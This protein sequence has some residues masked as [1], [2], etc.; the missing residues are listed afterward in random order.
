MAGE[1]NWTAFGKS[2]HRTWSDA[3]RESGNLDEVGGAID[4]LAGGPIKVPRRVDLQ[5][6]D[7]QPN[8]RTLRRGCKRQA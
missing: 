1:N 7:P 4:D 5:T 2:T 3:Q 8:S 6:G